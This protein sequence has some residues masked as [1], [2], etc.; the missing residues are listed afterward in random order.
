MILLTSDHLK[1]NH[2]LT[3]KTKLNVWVS[4]PEELV[5]VDN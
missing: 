2:V 3:Q 1:S 5:L 4:I